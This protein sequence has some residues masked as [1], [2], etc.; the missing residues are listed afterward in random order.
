MR[1]IL[2]AHLFPKLDAMLLELLRSLTAEDWE[3]QTVSPKWKVKDV[4]AHLLDTPL[5]GVS[6]ARDGYLPEAPR[7]SSSVELAAYI[8]RL[9]EEGVRLYR[10]LSPAVLISLMQVASQLLAEYHRSR[11]PDGNAPYGVSWAGEEKS[12]NWFDTAREFT[13]RWHHQQQIRLAVNKPGIMTR[14][15]YHPVLDCFL[16]ALPF[17]YRTVSAKPGTYVQ[18]NVSGECGGSWYLSRAEPGWQLTEEPLGD[19]LSETTI[20]QEIAWRIF[21][22]GIDRES[23]LPQVKIWGDT[24]LGLHALQ[25]ISIVA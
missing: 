25:V 3:K 4:A 23:A 10:R 5:R 8:N 17:T 12:A 1:P 13:E 22:K 21:T 18:I 16:R 6:I 20:P 11:D 7:I 19:K 2:T 24:Q 15:L 9:N 14:E